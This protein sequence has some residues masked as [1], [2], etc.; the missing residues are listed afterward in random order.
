[1]KINYLYLVFWL[2]LFTGH[3]QCYEHSEDEYNYYDYGSEEEG[4]VIQESLEY[5]YEDDYEVC[6]F[7]EE[8]D[9]RLDA[10]IQ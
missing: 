2:S 8:C 4:G 5:E 7:Q 1:M 10:F 6:D 3:A 9:S